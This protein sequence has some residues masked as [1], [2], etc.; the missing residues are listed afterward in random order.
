MFGLVRLFK[1]C[2]Q[3]PPNTYWNKISGTCRIDSLLLGNAKDVYA[4]NP[5][6]ILWATGGFGTIVSGFQ[7][8][9][10]VSAVGDVF[11]EMNGLLRSKRDFF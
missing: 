8:R 3:M 1:R 10:A 9:Y 4:V 7:T 2:H 5:H 11:K 6:S